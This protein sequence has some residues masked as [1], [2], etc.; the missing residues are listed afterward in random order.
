MSEPP[1]P[2]DR[3]VSRRSAVLAGTGLAYTS[4]ALVIVRNLGLVPLFVSVIG[5]HEYGAWLATGAVLVQITNVDFGLL[6]VLGQRVSRAYGARDRAELES[7]I[8]SGLWVVAGIAVVVGAIAAS[9]SPLAAQ[10]MGID[11]EQGRRLT[12]CI[13]IAC[14]ANILQVAAFGLAEVLK[15]LQRPVLPGMHSVLGEALSLVL[16]VGLIQYGFGLYAISLGLALRG[17]WMLLGNGLSVLWVVVH[18]LKIRPSWNA[19]LVRSLFRDSSYVFATQLAF[20]LRAYMDP[21]LVG[22]ILGPI[23]A[24]IFAITLRTHEMVKLL[25]VQFGTAILPGLAHLFGQRDDQRLREIMAARYKTT[26]LVGAIGLGGCIALNQGFVQL[27]VGSDLYAGNTVNI[28]FAVSSLIFMISGCAYDG[29][30]IRGEFRVI[31]RVVWLDALGRLP[32]VIFAM[33]VWGLPGAAA[34]TLFS[35]IVLFAIPISVSL[36]RRHPV[37]PDELKRLGRQL[38]VV[39]VTLT[40]FALA[41]LTWSPAVEDWLSFVLKGAIFVGVAVLAAAAL[42]PAFVRFLR[43]RGTGSPLAG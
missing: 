13:L 9:I 16:T 17:G 14:G 28:L 21:L 3:P 38:A 43:R 24:G 1:D 18:Q 20:R 11:G 33:T 23:P 39:S 35:T 26:A 41:V 34:A 31:T 2:L 12:E 8:G 15:N 30:F 7:L 10:V 4:I 37:P 27:W 32:I 25:D 5:P 19:R 36:K 6:G 42:D 29:L 40:C 22:V